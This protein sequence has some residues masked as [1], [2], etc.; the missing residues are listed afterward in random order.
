[1]ADPAIAAHGLA[2]RFG[3]V[4]A[5]DGIDLAVEAGTVLG[6]LG[7]NGAGLHREVDAVQ[8]DDGTEA[9]DQPVDADRRVSHGRAGS[10]AART[11]AARCCRTG[12]WLRSGGQPA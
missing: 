2:K 6:L 9:L 3:P 4:V 10:A 11:G 1:M 7:P 5:L 12:S 8:R